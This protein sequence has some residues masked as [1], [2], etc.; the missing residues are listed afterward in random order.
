MNDD[1]HD[2]RIVTL[3]RAFFE[4]FAELRMSGLLSPEQTG[5]IIARIA[6][7]CQSQTEVRYVGDYTRALA[8]GDTL[9]EWYRQRQLREGRMP[10]R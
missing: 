4:L 10:Q 3:E 5:N 8:A 1:E 6:R 9:N 7:Q 2:A